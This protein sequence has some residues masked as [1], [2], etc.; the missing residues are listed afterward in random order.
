M[1]NLPRPNNSTRHIPLQIR[2]RQRH[3]LPNMRHH[4][5]PSRTRKEH[6]LRLER[7]AHMLLLLL[8][9]RRRR[10]GTGER[11]GYELGDDVPDVVE[12]VSFEPFAPSDGVLDAERKQITVDL[13][14]QNE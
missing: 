2:Q 9:L 13:L 1:I 6:M 11:T 10:R 14:Y 8:L 3:V 12:P 5:D 4:P 7:L